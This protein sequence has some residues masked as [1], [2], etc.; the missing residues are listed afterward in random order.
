MDFFPFKFVDQSSED[1]NRKQG[2][3]RVGVGLF[4]LMFFSVFEVNQPWPNF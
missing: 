4:L 3:I 2:P 1:A